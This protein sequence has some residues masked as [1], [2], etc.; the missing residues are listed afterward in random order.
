MLQMPSQQFCLLTE[1]KE[2]GMG[3]YESAMAEPLTQ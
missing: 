2:T 3:V 1:P